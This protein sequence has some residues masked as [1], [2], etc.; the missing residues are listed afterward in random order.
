MGT[1]VHMCDSSDEENCVEWNLADQEREDAAEQLAEQLANQR[2]VFALRLAKRRLVLALRLAKR[3]RRVLALRIANRRRVLALRR[4][5]VFALRAAQERDIC[6]ICLD[7][8]S[9]HAIQLRC[10]HKYCPGCIKAWV[11]VT[12]KCP[13]CK[14]TLYGDK[15]LFPK[16]DK[17]HPI[18]LDDGTYGMLK[19]EVKCAYKKPVYYLMHEQTAFGKLMTAYGELTGQ[20]VSTMIFLYSE[21]EGDYETIRLRP[22]DSSKGLRIQSDGIIDL[23]QHH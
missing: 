7:L 16:T 9:E 4:R 17:H 2:R 18:R 3:R 10:R 15:R 12:P 20:D 23:F 5:R 6:A 8:L 11:L 14:A 19:F 21:V 22:H 13:C 1:C